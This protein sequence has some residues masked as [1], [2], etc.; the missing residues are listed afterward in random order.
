MERQ[1]IIEENG[2]HIV[3]EI[4][5]DGNFKLLHFSALPFQEDRIT[6][7]TKEAGFNRDLTALMKD[8]EISILLL[9]MV[10]G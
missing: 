3:F 6:V 2:I 1:I 8:M 7:T 5:A 10:S 9:L 4:E